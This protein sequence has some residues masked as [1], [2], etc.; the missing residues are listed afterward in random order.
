M[1]GAREADA[2]GFDAG[3]QHDFVEALVEQRLRF[4][5]RAEPHVN[6]VHAQL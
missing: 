1:S 3:G 5:A 6:G 4:H 2:A